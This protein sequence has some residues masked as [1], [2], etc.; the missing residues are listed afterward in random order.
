MCELWH[1]YLAIHPFVF[2]RKWGALLDAVHATSSPSHYCEQHYYKSTMLHQA[3]WTPV[4]TKLYYGALH[5][6]Y[7][8]LYLG[9]MSTRQQQLS[10]LSSTMELTCFLLMTMAIV[11]KELSSADWVHRSLPSTVTML[12]ITIQWWKPWSDL[13]RYMALILMPRRADCGA[14]RTLFIWLLWRQVKK[15]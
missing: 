6:S 1:I 2:Q 15:L 12:R 8:V 4:D 13:T 5:P 3:T 10:R 7:Q 9:G 11:A 14:C